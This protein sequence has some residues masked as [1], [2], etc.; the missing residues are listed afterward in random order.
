[1]KN[2]LLK[3]TA[4]IIFAFMLLSS[5]V[6]Q[7]SATQ[8]PKVAAT[9]E[10][11]KEAQVKKVAT[12]VNNIAAAAKI[13]DGQKTKLQASLLEGLMKSDAALAEIKGDNTKLKTWREAKLADMITRLK[14]I[15][16]TA[17]FEQAMKNGLPK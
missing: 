14:A 12:I 13:S 8:Q 5:N 1:M 6:Q 11:I 7:T 4:F 16:T 2:F 17:Q 9:K 3:T 10:E 15:L